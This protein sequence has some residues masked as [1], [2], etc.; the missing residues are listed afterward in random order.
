VIFRNQKERT[1]RTGDLR[2]SRRKNEENRYSFEI[3][4]KER[5]EQ[6]IFREWKERKRSTLPLIM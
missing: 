2:I 5:G 6:V 3:R 1:R 4:K